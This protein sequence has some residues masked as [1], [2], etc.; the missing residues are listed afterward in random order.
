MHQKLFS[1]QD[2]HPIYF[3]ILPETGVLY[4]LLNLLSTLPFQLQWLRF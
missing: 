3:E 1:G 4:S 2:F